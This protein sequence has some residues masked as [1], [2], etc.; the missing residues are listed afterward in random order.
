MI[1][2]PFQKLLTDKTGKFLFASV[3]NCIHVFRLIDGA[4]IGCWED[5]IRL[6]DVQEKKFKTQEQP[7][8]RSKTNN[9][10]PKVPVPGPG[11]PPIYNYIRSLTLSRDEQYVIGTTDS[12]KAAVI[13]KIDITQDNCLSLIKR[14]VFPKRPCAISTTLDDSQLIV[15]DKF[16]DVYSIPID[17]DEPVDEKTLQPILGHVSML[18]DVLVAQRNNRQYILTGDRDEH[19]RVTHFPKSYVVKHWLFGHKEFVSCLHILN[20]DSN[21]LISGGGDDFLILWNW[22][23]AK[24][25]ASVDLRQYVKAHL[26]EF[27]LPPERFRNNDLKKEISIAKADSFTVDNRNFLAVLC[28]H[29]NCIVTFIINDDLTF[30]HKQTLSTH[31]LIVDFTFTGEEII[32][33]LDTESDSQLL[34]SYGFNSEGLLHKKDSDIM[35][36]ITSAS[37]CDVISRDEFY[38]LYYISSL[39]KRSD[40]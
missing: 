17:A 11:A 27:H 19:I 23:S 10:E 35:Q 12:D 7:N 4:L 24:R 34:E 15:A 14:Q 16:G 39:R 22:H 21:L 6:Q 37:T 18:S 31:D 36:K 8:K 3:K 5:E 13:F 20:F 25:L 26:N 40:H 2:H 28:E 38:P 32:L 29:T 1:K 9:K 30:A 33:S